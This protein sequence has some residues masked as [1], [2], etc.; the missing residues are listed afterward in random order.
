MT[1]LFSDIR[2]FSTM[3]EQLTPQQTFNFLNSYLGTIGSIIRKHNGFIDKYIGD[4]IMALFPE[5]VEEAVRASLE[6]LRNLNEYNDIREELGEYPINVGIGLHCGKVMLG[7]IGEKER[8]EGTVISDTVNIASRLEG[9]KKKYGVKFIISESIFR[10]INDPNKY[11]H[12][13]L[14]QVAIKGKTDKV[15]IFEIFD[16]DDDDEKTIQMKLNTIEDLE[17]GILFYNM[18]QPDE[19]ESVFKKIISVFPDDRVSLSYLEEIKI[20]KSN[21]Y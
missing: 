12:R 9:L 2:S 13:F 5:T 19:A 1:I 14:G 10:E 7:I 8:M 15:A 21:R 20:Q 16:N 18:D 17:R 4:A 3:S 11:L 6:L